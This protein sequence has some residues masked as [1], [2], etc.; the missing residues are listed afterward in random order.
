MLAVFSA[1]QDRLFGGA[2]A[3][4]CIR[5]DDPWHLPQALQKLAEEFFRRVPVPPALH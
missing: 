5:D 1:R 4:Q 2:I 3:A